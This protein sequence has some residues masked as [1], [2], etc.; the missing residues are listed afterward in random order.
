MIADIM[1]DKSP[2][3]APGDGRYRNPYLD[4]EA[5]VDNSEEEEMDEE[6]EKEMGEHNLV[7]VLRHL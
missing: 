2:Q 1:S 6:M 3:S 5:V 7:S 4:L